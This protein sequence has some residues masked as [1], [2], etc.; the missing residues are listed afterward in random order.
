[1]RNAGGTISVAL[2]A[3]LLAGCAGNAGP[4]KAAP[5]AINDDPYPSTYHAYPGTP[6]VIRGATIYDGEGGQVDNGTIVLADGVVQA[7]GGPETPVPA[8]AFEVDGHGKWVTPGIIDIHSHLG[9]YPSPGTEGNSD[10]NEATAPARPDVWA[11]HSVWPQDPGF[12]RALANGGV[13]A[14]QILPGSANLFGG[15]SVTI[16]NVPART[17]QGMNSPARPMA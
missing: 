13:T 16:K 12:T 10:G 1:M 8:G 2:T 3:A 5:I 6:T 14:L 9:D 17:V 11:E 15:R 7:V 4:K